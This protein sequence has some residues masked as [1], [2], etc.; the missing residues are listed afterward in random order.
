MVDGKARNVTACVQTD[1]VD[2]WRNI[3]ATV[4]L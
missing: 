1:I 4:A 3:N 2:G